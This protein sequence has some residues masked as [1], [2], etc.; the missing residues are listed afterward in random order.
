[1]AT[2]FSRKDFLEALFES[3]FQ[4][5]DGFIVVQSS[6][7]LTHKVSTR[8]FPSVEILAKERFSTDESVL[9][10]VC[11]REK[12][13]PGPENIQF[14]CALWAGLDMSSEG[15]SGRDSFF[16]HPAHAAKAIRSFPLPPSIIIESGQGIHLYWLLKEPYAVSDPS[17]VEILLSQLNRYFQ[18]TK[19]IDLSTMLRLPGTSNLKRPGE[20]IECSAKY[21]NPDFRYTLSEFAEMSKDLERIAAA[22]VQTTDTQQASVSDQDA[23]SKPPS[24]EDPPQMTS[25]EVQTFLDNREA[26]QQFSSRVPTEIVNAVDAAEELEVSEEPQ[27]GTDPPTT[28]KADSAGN[29]VEVLSEDSSDDFAERIAQMVVDRIS[30]EL[31][32]QIVEKIFQR[33]AARKQK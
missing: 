4:R 2:G 27:T 3:Y 9:F 26:K 16:G 1:M 18:C 28:L 30:D 24:G 6:K 29:E 31:V 11:P 7:P 20:P 32:D 23:P 33:L 19:K 5:R 17:A 12:M 25:S 22:A 8:Y 13:K 15:F 14:L 10:G 21:V